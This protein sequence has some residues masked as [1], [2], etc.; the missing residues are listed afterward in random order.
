MPIFGYKNYT[1][2]LNL[3]N[4]FRSRHFIITRWIMKILNEIKPKY[5]LSKYISHF[6]LF[7]DP[8]LW[9]KKVPVF[10]KNVKVHNKQ[11]LWLSLFQ[12]FNMV[13]FEEIWWILNMIRPYNTIF[14]KK[15]IKAQVNRHFL[16]SLSKNLENGK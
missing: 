7:Q 9:C 12:S 13:Y 6:F 5:S 3:S 15:I 14:V 10:F 2:F 11:L 1:L 16:I 8:S 4:F